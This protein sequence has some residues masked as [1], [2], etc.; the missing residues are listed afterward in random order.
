MQSQVLALDFP[1]VSLAWYVFIRIDMTLA[2]TKDV[3]QELAT[4]VINGMPK[5]SLMFLALD[6]RRHLISFGFLSKLNHHL[7]LFWI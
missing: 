7:Y 1:R 2:T 6:K 5:P 3:G 4:V